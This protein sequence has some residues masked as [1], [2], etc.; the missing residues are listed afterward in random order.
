MLVSAHET[1]ANGPLKALPFRILFAVPDLKATSSRLEAS[2]FRAGL[3]IA[4]SPSKIPT[5][6]NSG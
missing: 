4:Q 6:I 2:G 5:A 1:A 3:T